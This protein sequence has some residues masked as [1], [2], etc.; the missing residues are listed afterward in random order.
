MSSVVVVYVVRECAKGRE[1]KTASLWP[2]ISGSRVGVG[3]S[4]IL[5][6]PLQWYTWTVDEDRAKKN[7][8]K[9]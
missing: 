4:K 2:Y 6:S 5:V 1:E 8:L 9:A 3:Q 7:L